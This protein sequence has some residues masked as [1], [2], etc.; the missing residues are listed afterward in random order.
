MKPF[1]QKVMELP[2][3]GINGMA[4][5][6]QF[7]INLRNLSMGMMTKWPMRSIMAKQAAKADAIALKHY[8]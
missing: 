3:G 2:P 5:R 7:M 8:G 4:P 6:S 1:V